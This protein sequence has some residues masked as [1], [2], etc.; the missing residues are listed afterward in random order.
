MQCTLFGVN[1][2]PRVPGGQHTLDSHLGTPILT[3]EHFAK[4]P[5]SKHFRF[6]AQVQL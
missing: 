3:P 2:L 6:I 1:T 5:L 4:Q